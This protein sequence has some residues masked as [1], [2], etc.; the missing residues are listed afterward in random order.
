M[1]GKFSLQYKNEV[2]INSIKEF[3]SEDK[4]QLKTKSWIEIPGRTLVVVHGRVIIAPEHCERLYNI[5]AHRR[6]GK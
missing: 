6:N 2:L 4:P 3:F 1:K 5:Q